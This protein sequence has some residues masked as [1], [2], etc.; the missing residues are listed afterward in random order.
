MLSIEEGQDYA[1]VDEAELPYEHVQKL[2][3]G[4]SGTV[5]HVKH[6]LTNKSY[7]RKTF[8][9]RRFRAHK[10]E[11]TKIFNNEVQIIRSLGNHRHI[12][13]VFATYCTKKD[14]GLILEPVA[15]DGDLDAYLNE[16][17]EI[18]NEC[19]HS[20]TLT[21][22]LENMSSVLRRAF[23]CLAVGLAFIH[24]KKV[25]HKDIK[26]HNILLHNGL[27][28]YADFGY[29]FDHSA[30][31]SSTTDGRPEF[32]TPRYSAPEVLKQE[33]R[34]SSSDIFSLGCVFIEILSVL[35]A[36]ALHDDVTSFSASMDNVH[37][38]LEALQTPPW[39]SSL[40]TVVINMT[41]REPSKRF[42][43]TQVAQ[44]ILSDSES[45]C[46]DCAKTAPDPRSTPM[47]EQS[48]VG[49]AVTMESVSVLES[50]KGTDIVHAYK[51]AAR[52]GVFTTT[53]SSEL[54]SNLTGHV[55][56]NDLALDAC[57]TSGI[58]EKLQN[59]Q[60]T[61]EE[62]E[63]YTNTGTMTTASL[64][65]SLR[66]ESSVVSLDNHHASSD[67]TATVD[68]LTASSRR[69]SSS[70]DVDAQ[71]CTNSRPR[72]QRYEVIPIPSTHNRTPWMWS[73]THQ[74]HYYVVF[75]QESE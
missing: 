59:Y 27:V 12:I 15:S 72:A 33:E 18:K 41:I 32:L 73:N 25:R 50:I 10:D 9:V 20:E 66:E 51:D 64:P 5:E 37:E 54:L 43:A 3:Q 44:K 42:C 70:G 19:G 74:N 55:S 31:S 40:A 14:F 38:Q 69:P 47:E 62:A 28:V 24:E 35:T 56:S 29:S 4:N 60:A 49:R 26:P 8:V 45:C 7:A 30:I 63:L 34:N 53:K 61:V 17:C 36:T 67:S 2:G 46:T 13:S 68:S 57:S 39:S 48:R 21:K 75:D 1:N 65:S 11:V 23:G 22:R 52:P 6:R 16:Y 71:V 58:V